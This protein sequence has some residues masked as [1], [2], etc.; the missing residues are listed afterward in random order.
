M[1]VQSRFAEAAQTHIHCKG[2]A[3]QVFSEELSIRD[4]LRQRWSKVSAGHEAFGAGGLIPWTE[5]AF[6]LAA[7]RDLD[8]DGHLLLV[9]TSRRV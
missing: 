6:G 1:R 2:F 3:P 9:P 4:N 8:V 7:I 5:L